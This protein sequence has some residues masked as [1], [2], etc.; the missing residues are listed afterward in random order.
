M[1]ME[2]KY[3]INQANKYFESPETRE[4]QEWF[5]QYPGY[6]EQ[7]KAIRE[8]LGLTQEQLAKMVDR[9]PRAIRTI[10]NGEA[11]PRISTL[12][13]IAEALNAEL[14]IFLVPRQ[15]I[16]STQNKKNKPKD[17]REEIIF[18]VNERNDICFGETD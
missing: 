5:S 2:K 17:D 14:N 8:S 6:K 10:E 15:G 18:P 12:Q 11:F 3:F 13:S 9:T 4:I 16:P 1:D 7:V